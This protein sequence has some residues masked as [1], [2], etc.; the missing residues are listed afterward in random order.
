[1]NAKKI[2]KEEGIIQSLYIGKKEIKS[3]KSKLKNHSNLSKTEIIEKT[4]LYFI[5]Q[6]YLQ[7]KYLHSELNASMRAILV[8][9]MIEVCHDYNLKRDTL[10]E[11]V[12]ILDRFL[13]KKAKLISKENL[14]LIGAIC[15]FISSKKEEIQ[16]LKIENLISLCAN[17]FSKKDIEE[18]E[19]NILQVNFHK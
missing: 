4:K 5:E 16:P 12:N 11:A 7:T 13:T 2:N 19:F 18:M 8:D 15:L 6:N 1:M 14:Q 10:Y 17:S 3:P 9:W